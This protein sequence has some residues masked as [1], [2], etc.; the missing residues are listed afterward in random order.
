MQNFDAAQ[1]LHNLDILPGGLIANFIE[2]VRFLFTFV[3]LLI[4][5]MICLYYYCYAKFGEDP[6]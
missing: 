1:Q 6:C 2:Y 4:F 3:V 5:L